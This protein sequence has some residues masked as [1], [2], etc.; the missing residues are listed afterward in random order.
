MKLVKQ[1][2]SIRLNLK[3]TLKYFKFI[4]FYENTKLSRSKEKEILM[5]PLDQSFT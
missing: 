4:K 3:L 2:I 5:S 1:E